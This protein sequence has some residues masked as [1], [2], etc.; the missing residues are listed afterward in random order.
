MDVEQ[1]MQAGANEA[2]NCSNAFTISM[3]ESLVKTKGFESQNESNYIC[4]L[5]DLLLYRYPALSK[6]VFEL[7]MIYFLRTRTVTAGLL[8]V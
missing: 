4:I 3:F 8:N 2:H 7:L 5:F 6:L 1:E